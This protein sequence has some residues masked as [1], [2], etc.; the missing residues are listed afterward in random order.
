MTDV[1]P[2]P[3][4][5]NDDRHSHIGIRLQYRTPDEKWE[6]LEALEWNAVGFNFYHADAL[7]SPELQLRRGLTRFTGTVA[8][9]SLN[10]SDDVVLATVVNRLLYAKAK[11]I[12]DNPQLHLRLIK[13]LRVPG[14]VPEKLKVLASLGASQSDAK[15][16]ELVAQRKQEH[17]TY[18]YGVRVQSTA[19]VGIVESALSVSSVLVSLDRWS[20]AL[21][22]P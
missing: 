8:W 13:L 7:P 9:Q 5:R 6:Y 14:M 3:M 1:D 12:A 2:N 15:M 21:G 10:T 11:G 19:W 18:H 20:G 16:A 22:K 4:A 17:P